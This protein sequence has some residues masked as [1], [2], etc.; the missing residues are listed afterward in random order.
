MKEIVPVH[1]DFDKGLKN[2]HLVS[3]VADGANGCGTKQKKFR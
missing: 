3:V 1:G 2:M